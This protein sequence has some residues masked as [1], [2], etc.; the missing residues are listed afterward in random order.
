MITNKNSETIQNLKNELK[1]ILK[2]VNG[3]RL[4]TFPSGMREISSS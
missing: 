1:K 4:G 2:T 3:K